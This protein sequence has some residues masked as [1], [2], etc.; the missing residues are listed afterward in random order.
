MT[1][2]RIKF[3][4]LIKSSK[5]GKSSSA[6]KVPYTQDGSP[7]GKKNQAGLKTRLNQM[8]DSH[9]DALSQLLPNLPQQYKQKALTGEDP[10]VTPAYFTPDQRALFHLIDLA[11]DEREL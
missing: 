6:S 5:Q 7:A 2:V 9:Y 11:K 10:V 3:K 1:F 4:S 8:L